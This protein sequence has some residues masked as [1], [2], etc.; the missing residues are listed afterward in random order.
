MQSMSKTPAHSTEKQEL[1]KYLGL[2]LHIFGE[3]C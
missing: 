1:F 2:P 3:V